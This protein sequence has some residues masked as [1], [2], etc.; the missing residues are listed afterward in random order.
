MYE[1]LEKFVRDGN[2][3]KIFLSGA[4]LR[5][6][7]S[8]DNIG[9]P[10]KVYGESAYLSE[11]LLRADRSIVDGPLKTSDYVFGSPYFESSLDKI[12][13]NGSAQIRLSESDLHLVLEYKNSNMIIETIY[14]DSIEDLIN[15]NILI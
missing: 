10:A 2:P 3:I 4:R 7:R 14:G 1:N 11:A 5:V 8:C 15:R 12:L 13:G 6:V 9:D